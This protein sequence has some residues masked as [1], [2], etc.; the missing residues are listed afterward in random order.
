[1]C[2]LKHTQIHAFLVLPDSVAL[3]FLDMKGFVCK[4]KKG[5]GALLALGPH[6]VSSGL[7]PFETVCLACCSA[8]ER[9]DGVVWD[10]DG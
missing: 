1:M 10:D 2:T 7:Y 3:A 8:L 5:T 6:D 9:S 4:Q